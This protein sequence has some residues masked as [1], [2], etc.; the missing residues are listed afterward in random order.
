MNAIK[1]L[2]VL[3]VMFLVTSCDKG[4]DGPDGVLGCYENVQQLPPNV[5]CIDFI[6]SDPRIC[7]VT[8]FG[9]FTLSNIAKESFPWFCMDTGDKISYINAVGDE[10]E[11]T[12]SVK[13]FTETLTIFAA[14]TCASDPMKLEGLCVQSQVAIMQLET[15]NDTRIVRMGLLTGPDNS[16]VTMGEVGDYFQIVEQGIGNQFV[17]AYTGVVDQRSLP[18]SSLPQ[19]IFE[20]DFM[21]L[22]KAF[23]DVTYMDFGPGETLTQ[24]Y[25]SPISGLVGFKDVDG[26]EWVLND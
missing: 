17:T 3:S 11:F 16:N 22:G 19:E 4:T 5:S 12:I 15:P 25:Y 9:T 8:P 10:I 21:L 2:L 6:S 26:T 1:L 18:F 23:T 13:N 14:D 20:A 24:Y 7:D